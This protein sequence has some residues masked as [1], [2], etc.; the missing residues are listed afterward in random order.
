MN[1]EEEEE[2]EEEEEEKK[3]RE[4]FIPAPPLPPQPHPR[5]SPTPRSYPISR[6][7]SL[8]RRE[9]EKKTPEDIQR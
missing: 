5:F 6:V 4:K 3:K 2:D 9:R 8:E 1:E 7:T